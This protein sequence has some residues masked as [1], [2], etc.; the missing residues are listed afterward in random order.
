MLSHSPVTTLSTRARSAG[1]HAVPMV[2]IGS[3]VAAGLSLSPVVIESALAATNGSYVIGD[4]PTALNQATDAGLGSIAPTADAAEQGMFGPQVAWPLLPLHATLARNGH[5]ITYG[6]P[7]GGNAQNGTAFDDWDPTAGYGADTHIDTASMHAYDSFCNSAVTLLDGRMLMVSGQYNQPTSS[8]SMT[9]LYDP[10]T[11]TQDMGADLAYKRWYVTALRR[12]DGQI[13]LLGGK[14]VGNQNPN[15]PNIPAVTPEIG[16]GTGAWR[17]LTGASSTALFG[18]QDAHWWYPRAFNG[19]DGDVVGLSGDAVWALSTEG[20]G[21]IRQTGTLPFNPKVSGSQVMYAPGKVLVAGGGQYENGDAVNATAQAAVVDFNGATPTITSVAPM[22]HQRNWL[23][24]TVLPTGEVLANGGTVFG[25]AA[26]D[27]NSVRQAEVWSPAAGTWRPAATAQRTRTYHSTSVLLPSG[28]VFTG[29]GGGANYTGGIDFGPENNLNAE[30]YYPSYLFAKGANGAVQWASRPAISAISGSATYGGDVR[31]R[32]GDGRAIASASLISLPAVTHSQ[33]TDQRRIPL[34]ITQKA[35]TV[36]AMLP[37]SVNTMPPGDYALSVVDGNGVPSASQ[38]ITIRPGQAGLVTVGNGTAVAADDD[39]SAPAAGTPAGK[40]TGAGNG[41]G[42]AAG[43]GAGA[44]AGNG[45][46][47]DG[48]TA[49]AGNGSGDAGTATSSPGTTNAPVESGPAPSGPTAPTA[50]VAL[51]KGASISIGSAAR[52]GYRLSHIGA[53]VVLT[54]VGSASSKAARKAATWIVRTGLG[55]RAGV[56]FESADKRGYFL[57][58]TANGA[59]KVALVKRSRSAGF[60]KRAVFSVG[61]GVMGHDSAIHLAATPALVLQ[62]TGTRLVLAEQR[63][64]AT[65]R[66]AATFALRKGL[67]TLR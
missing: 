44:A 61:L 46:P 22:A 8:E 12:T 31:L 25:T 65:G 23:N 48:A 19:P 2:V 59:A 16:S 66:M 21:S 24:L 41:G 9:M 33:N 51:T 32:I 17:D 18:M 38:I 11:R 64:S 56:S 58:A 50:G 42:T 57:A 5:L 27:A 49:A 43:N 4:Q 6:S 63:T 60:S 67:A 47:A 54:K 20:D 13:L 1:R 55:S 7:L 40:G 62:N 14:D 34:D 36:N 3:L 15:D 29:G 53:R 45:T 37:A 28:A 30:I 39:N 35:G 10:A 26:G 52:A